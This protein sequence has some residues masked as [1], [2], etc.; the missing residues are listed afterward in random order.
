MRYHTGSATKTSAPSPRTQPEP[1][2][3]DATLLTLYALAGEE[4]GELITLHPRLFR[5]IR[6]HL[7]TLG[8]T[9]FAHPT[10]Q[11]VEVRELSTHEMCRAEEELW[12]HDKL[13]K[14]DIETDRLFAAF[15]GTQLVGVARCSRQPDGYEVDSVYVLE[16]YR[17]QGFARLVMKR[18]IEECGRHETLYLNAKPELVEFYRE[19]GFVPVQTPEIPD[20]FH[21]EPDVSSLGENGT[22][23]MKRNPSPRS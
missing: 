14:A 1:A 16:E 23:S 12:I 21:H 20:T 2:G 6:Q 9:A 4:C 22:C 5:I 8:H 11:D 15:S 10:S 19:M 18:L 3:E 7:L 17:H 13:Q